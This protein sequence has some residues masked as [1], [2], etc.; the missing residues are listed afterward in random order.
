MAKLSGTFRHR[1][2]KEHRESK[3]IPTVS[4]HVP[5]S[6]SLPSVTGGPA[7]NQTDKQEATEQTEVGGEVF[8]VLKSVSSA[9]SADLSTAIT[10]RGRN[11]ASHSAPRN[12]AVAAD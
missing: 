5:I 2:R 8:H 6:T 4:S 9:V 1:A 11:G 7:Q 10:G 12:P 3:Q